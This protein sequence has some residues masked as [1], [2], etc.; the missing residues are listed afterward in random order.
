MLNI[1]LTAVCALLLGAVMLRLK[2]PGGMIIGA[3]LGA[4]ILNVA[5][6]RAQMPYIV[7]FFAQSVAAPSSEVRLREAT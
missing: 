1:I 5:T 6:G 7:R 4:I 2:V 3:I